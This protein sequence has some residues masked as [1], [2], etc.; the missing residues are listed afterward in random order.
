VTTHD[1]L[2]VL[3]GSHQVT[4][5]RTLP[6]WVQMQ[7][8]LVDQYDARSLPWCITSVM[9]VELGGAPRHV[10]G[11]DN[12]AALTVGKAGEGNLLT[13]FELDPQL[14]VIDAVIKALRAFQASE[15]SLLDGLEVR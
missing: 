7:L 6:L 11:E 13:A 9:W 5:D 3:E 8:D 2:D 4:D 1:E 12:Q 14:L 15:C 10:G